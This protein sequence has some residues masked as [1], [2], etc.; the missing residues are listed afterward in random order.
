MCV[1]FEGGWN[2]KETTE[3]AQVEGRAHGDGNTHKHM[4]VYVC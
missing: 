4:F 1:L 3:G 2:L